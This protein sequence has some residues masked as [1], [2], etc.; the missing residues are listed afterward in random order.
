[1]AAFGAKDFLRAEDR[2]WVLDAL[3]LF[4]AKLEG[5]KKGHACQLT[6]SNEQPFERKDGAVCGRGTSS[7]VEK[8]ANVFRER[9]WH[10]EISNSTWGY[11]LT[12]TRRRTAWE[13]I[14][15]PSV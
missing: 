11:F 5:L 12:F 7:R 3:P 15:D 10:V 8:L 14:D 6:I 9:G 13:H 4:E 1:M 2:T